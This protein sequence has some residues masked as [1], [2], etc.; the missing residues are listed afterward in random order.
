M[1]DNRSRGNDTMMIFLWF[2]S[3]APP[4]WWPHSHCFMSCLQTSHG[5][6]CVHICH[7]GCL[8]EFT[9]CVNCDLKNLICT[10]VWTLPGWTNQRPLRNQCQLWA[11]LR[12][13]NQQEKWLLVWKQQWRL[14]QASVAAGYLS[15]QF[16]DKFLVVSSFT[17][18]STRL[19]DN[20]VNDG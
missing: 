16:P 19:D 10:C 3:L 15:K 6:L 4:P 8:T 17:S 5:H 11:W 12:S 9:H 18:S 1:Y 20:F 13:D 7:V 2:L 14:F